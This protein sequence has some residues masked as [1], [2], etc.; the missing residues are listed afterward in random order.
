MLTSPIASKPRWFMVFNLDVALI[1]ERMATILATAVRRH[2][3]PQDGHEGA[4]VHVDPDKRRRHTERTSAVRCAAFQNGSGAVC[5][6]FLVT[7]NLLTGFAKPFERCDG[8]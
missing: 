3:C 7:L 8:H 6:L 1:D 4:P 5:I 2:Q